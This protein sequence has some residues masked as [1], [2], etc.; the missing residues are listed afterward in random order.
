MLN[1]SNISKAYGD[2]NLFS[3]L[4]LNVAAR[5]RIALIGSNGSGKTTQCNYRLSQAGVRSVLR[6]NPAPRCAGGVFRG[7]RS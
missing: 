7:D 2:R 6:Q 4:T 3:G 5:N 1:A